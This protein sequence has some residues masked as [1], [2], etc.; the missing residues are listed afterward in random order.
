[1]PAPTA[2]KPPK[3]HAFTGRDVPWLLAQRARLRA[4]HPFFIW[5]PFDQPAE[6][7]SY[8]RFADEVDRLAGGLARDGV[9]LGD[10]VLIHLDNCPE[11]L[12]AWF[13]CA[14]LGAVAVTTN[15]RSSA[16]ELEYFVAHSDSKVA[17]T[18]PKYAASVS[19]AGPQLNWIAVTA[20]DNGEPPAA[21][22]ISGVR[23]FSSLAGDRADAPERLPDPMLANSVQYT[24]GTTSRPKGVVWTHANALFGA[25][26]TAMKC[27]ITQADI[28]HACLPLYH[29]NSLC[30]VML[31]TLWAGASMVVQPR[32][33]ARRYWP[34]FQTH[35]VTW[36]TAIPFILRALA[37]HPAPDRHDVRF[38]G[39]G[40]S[41]VRLTEQM[42]NIRSLGWFGMTETVSQPL[43]ADF[44]WCNREMSM[45]RPALDCEVRIVDEAGVDAPF[46]TSGRLQIRGVPG[47]TLFLEYLNDPAATAQAFDPE[48]WFDTGDL[49]TAFADG[50]IRYDGRNKDMLRIGAENVAASEIERVIES[51]PGVLESAV[52]GKP[53]ALLDEVAVAFVIAPQGEALRP[54]IEEACARRLADFK[55][56]R[57]IRFLAEFPRVT[58]EKTDKK[59]LRR[60]LSTG[61]ET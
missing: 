6:I 50:D 11:F 14:R 48:G 61:T 37:Q 34:C 18:Q 15:T 45:G 52:V 19:T 29:T 7:W 21:A 30:Y 55:V 4:D 57:E 40:A 8:A 42:F 10:K 36:A 25:K 47:L 24:S 51:V 58:L 60:L 16:E 3:L 20:T 35:R 41:E 53:H 38:W 5:A 43:M 39:L 56:P 12:L 33:S 2:L 44:E 1:M 13:A 9:G 27:R 23:A 32:F 17:I 54:A 49:A 28:G 59:A 22:R 31:S 46:G 26:Q